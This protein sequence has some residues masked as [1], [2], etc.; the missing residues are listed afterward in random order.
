MSSLCITFTPTLASC[1]LSGESTPRLHLP[2]TLLS[3]NTAPN[4]ETLVELYSS[5]FNALQYPQT[6]RQELAVQ[7]GF[8]TI[9]PPRV[10]LE[11]SVKALAIVQQSHSTTISPTTTTTTDPS[12]PPSPIFKLGCTLSLFSNPAPQTQDLSGLVIDIDPLETHVLGGYQGRSLIESYRVLSG[13]VQ[14]FQRDVKLSLPQLFADGE[15]TELSMEEFRAVLYRHLSVRNDDAPV[16]DHPSALFHSLKALTK[17][18]F[19]NPI[20]PDHNLFE[21]IKKSLALSP[22]DTRRALLSNIVVVGV[23]GDVLPWIRD[24]LRE[25]LGKDLY[26]IGCGGGFVRGGN[27]G[28]EDDM[29]ALSLGGGGGPAVRSGDMNWLGLSVCCHLEGGVETR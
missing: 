20:D 19:F 21:V 12:L 2:T 7:I 22:I 10:F 1:G 16:I 13:G 6:D 23:G 3:S 29:A 28:V 8:S 5:I 25:E 24:M 27:S 11:G 15:N 17:D 4:T 9:Y 26:V 14:G 18:V